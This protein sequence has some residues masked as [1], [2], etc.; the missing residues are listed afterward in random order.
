MSRA[1]KQYHD[2]DPAEQLSLLSHWELAALRSSSASRPRKSEIA[3][4]KRHPQDVE[5]RLIQR[6]GASQPKL[7]GI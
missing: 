4:R 2:T 7:P 3:S 1:T 5:E 6:A